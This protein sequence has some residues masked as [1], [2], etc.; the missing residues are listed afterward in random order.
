M[1]YNCNEVLDY[2]HE[3]MRMCKTYERCEG[4]PLEE[5]ECDSIHVMTQQMVKILQ[6]WSDSHPESQKI[7]SA[8]L[9]FLKAFTNKR[10]T[11]V[12]YDDRRLR[13]CSGNTYINICSTMFNFID[14]GQPW[15]I[16]ALLQLEVQDE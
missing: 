6:E 12:R 1:K 8:E 9:E 15:T 13:I 11:I 5:Y 7:T 10:L 4:C 3:Y 14:E 16:E 2:S